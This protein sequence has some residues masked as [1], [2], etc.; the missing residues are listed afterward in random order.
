MGRHAA[1]VAVRDDWTWTPCPGCARPVFEADPSH[2][3]VGPV[4]VAD[5]C[6]LCADGSTARHA[7]L[8]PLAPQQRV[9]LDAVAAMTGQ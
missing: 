9:V 5:L 4:T 8:G 1:L 3:L 2:T 7:D 6:R